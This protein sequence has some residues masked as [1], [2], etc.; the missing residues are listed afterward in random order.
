MHEQ[1]AGAGVHDKREQLSEELLPHLTYDPGLEYPEA[2][3]RST[4]GRYG[5][6]FMTEE[7]CTLI[8]EMFEQGNIC[9]S[10]KKSQ[11]QVHEDLKKGLFKHNFLCPSV[12]AIANEYQKLGARTQAH[13]T[14]QPNRKRKLPG[15]VVQFIQN[16]LEETPD[17]YP[18]HVAEKVFVQFPE[19]DRSVK[20]NL[21]NKVSAIK[22]ANKKKKAR[23]D[24]NCL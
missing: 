11:W 6:T 23:I 21:K 4:K 22:T 3:G 10:S 12:S 2:W 17:Q 14:S 15:K 18:R 1:Y 19:L 16:S 9:K 8:E 7:L 24:D 13:G 5:E 20:K